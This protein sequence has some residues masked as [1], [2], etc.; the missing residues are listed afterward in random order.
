M[1]FPGILTRFTGGAKIPTMKSKL[2]LIVVFLVAGCSRAPDPRITEF[3]EVTKST[4][5]LLAES[6]SV[7]DY[8]LKLRAVE[9]CLSR[10]PDPG[11]EDQDAANRLAVAKKIVGQLRYGEKELELKT[12]AAKLPNSESIVARIK[13]SCQTISK[14]VKAEIAAF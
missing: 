11:P 3:L 7:E 8:R 1:G 14:K 13:D 9:V 12:S 5:N 10:L 4:A 6:P 2:A